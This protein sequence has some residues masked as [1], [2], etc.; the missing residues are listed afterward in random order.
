MKKNKLDSFLAIDFDLYGLVSSTKEYKLAWHLNKAMDIT[1]SKQDDIQIE[2]SDHSA[3]LI[4]Y[5]LHQTENLKIELLQNR[6]VSKGSKGNQYLVP[7]LSQFDLL[8]KY[9]DNTGERSSENVIELI[10][11][12]PLVEYVVRLNFDNLKSKENLLY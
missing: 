1:L 8:L 3:I 12:V 10:R 9:R 6:L 4:S 5:Y 2:F 11:V 7:E